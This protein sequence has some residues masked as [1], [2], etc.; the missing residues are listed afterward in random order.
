MSSKS[1]DIL[2]KYGDI[3]I[4]RWQPSVILNF[5]ISHYYYS[6]ILSLRRKFHVTHVGLHAL[7]RSTATIT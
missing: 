6:G 3:T 7:F 5:Q 4:S 1:E 2:L